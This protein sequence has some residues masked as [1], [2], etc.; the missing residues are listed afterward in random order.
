MQLYMILKFGTLAVL[1]DLLKIFQNLLFKSLTTF[2]AI[3]NF[4]HT[5]PMGSH[6][7]TVSI[8][9]FFQTCNEAILYASVVDTLAVTINHLVG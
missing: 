4:H 7:S 1:L 5:F 3:Q 6:K 8:V 2:T 9:V